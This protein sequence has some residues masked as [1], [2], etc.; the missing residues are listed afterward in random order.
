VVLSYNGPGAVSTEVVE[1][2]IKGYTVE[3][4]TLVVVAQFFDP[5]TETDQQ[6]WLLG[7]NT[8]PAVAKFLANKIHVAH[9]KKGIYIGIGKYGQNKPANTKTST[10]TV[11]KR[12]AR[13][14]VEEGV[15]NK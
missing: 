8:A 15:K 2:F 14:E 7:F 11:T 10:K 9:H 5:V 12:E 3:L 6:K 13:R 4:P 1:A